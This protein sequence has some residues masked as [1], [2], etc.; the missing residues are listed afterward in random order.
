VPHL[1]LVAPGDP[2]VP[3]MSLYVASVP[4]STS[5]LDVGITLW[6]SDL[7]MTNQWTDSWGFVLA[8]ADTSATFS[9]TESNWAGD[10]T[11]V[12]ADLSMASGV[13]TSVAGGVFVVG[14]TAFA[15]GGA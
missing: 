3:A 11:V 5:S 7:T 15:G 1:I 13:I 12:G 8:G 4:V 14:Y 9:P 2:V 10:P 6:V